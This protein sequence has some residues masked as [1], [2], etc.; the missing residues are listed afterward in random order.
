MDDNSDEAQSLALLLQADG[1]RVQLTHDGMQALD[2]ARGLQ[3]S[4]VLLDIGLPRM[5][6]YSV[7]RALRRDTRLAAA[8][9]VALSR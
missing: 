8:V 1:H 5:E 7:A 3:S 4:V 6:G 2:V 9:T